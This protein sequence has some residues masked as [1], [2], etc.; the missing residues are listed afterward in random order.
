MWIW[1]KE[2]KKVHPTLEPYR[3]KML[4]VWLGAVQLRSTK[5]ILISSRV[6][7][8][9]RLILVKSGHQ[10]TAGPVVCWTLM[11]NIY[12]A[13]S[14]CNLLLPHGWL[15]VDSRRVLWD[16]CWIAPMTWEHSR[17]RSGAYIQDG[18][19]EAEP[20]SLAGEAGPPTAWIL[21]TGLLTY[22]H[23][24]GMLLI[25]LRSKDEFM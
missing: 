4:I 23:L 18:S 7:E 22:S 19:S 12:Q 11:T 24:W 20:F 16:T 15:V 25:S 6:Q 21:R 17:V 9:D 2:K 13:W 3:L 1:L 14:A 10:E 8:R 5:C